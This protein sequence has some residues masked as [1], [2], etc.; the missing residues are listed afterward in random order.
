MAL[1][2]LVQAERDELIQPRHQM[3]GALLAQVQYLSGLAIAGFEVVGSVE[4]IENLTGVLPVEL[5]NQVTTIDVDGRHRD[6][7]LG[8]AAAQH[9]RCENYDI[10]GANSLLAELAEQ[11]RRPG[12]YDDDL[13]AVVGYRPYRSMNGCGSGNDRNESCRSPIWVRHELASLLRMR[14]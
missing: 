7:S 13:D 4:M 9:I 10:A 5:I 11:Y 8:F 1:K 14:V 6:P 3:P 2:V 12:T